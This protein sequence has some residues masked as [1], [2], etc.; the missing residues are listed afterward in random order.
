MEI[1]SIDPLICMLTLSAT[2]PFFIGVSA[3]VVFCLILMCALLLCS[4]MAS[5]SETA[6][7]S[8]Q[9]NDIN[10]LESSQN[11]NEQLVLEIRQKPKTLLVTILIFNNL[12][13]ISITIFSTYIM[14]MMFNLAVNPIAAFILNVI[15]V[16]SLIL[17]VGEM[18]PKV[19]ASKKAKSI[20]VLMAPILKVLILIFKPLS[21]VFVSSTSFI[22]KK[23][24]KKTGSISLS[25]LSTA[26]DIATE[27]GSSPEEKNMLKGIAT[28]GEKEVSDIMRPRVNM[29]SVSLETDFEELMKQVVD[30]GFSRIPVYDKDLDDVKGILYV[31]DLLPYIDEK[32]FAWQKLLR[33]A[34]FVPEN[35]KIND[36]FQ[37]FRAKKI[38]IAIVVDE[39]G[40]TSG[41][42]T[43][44]DIVEEIV[45]DISD[46]FDK[47]PEND[48]YKKI[49]NETYIFKAQISIVDFCKV[50]GIND[51]Y[52][53]EIEGESDTLAGII[54]EM[55]GR[56][57]E[58]GFKCSYKEFTFEIVESD[59]KHIIKIKVIRKDENI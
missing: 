48:N 18:I 16:T 43:L 55:E 26:V 11:H 42:V 46:E 7:F 52:F 54:L 40:G 37:D 8:L 51:D 30:K 32:D 5:S 50:F 10:E 44:E 53:E 35:K 13:N 22:D 23:L 28:F 57:P 27:E 2:E 12:V 9:P 41:L 45:G 59:N 34:F 29:F 56:I 36:L 49:D 20:A 25:D 1:A 17:L 31:K 21:N 33:P 38:H 24:V 14:S 58:T 3:K 15:V 4:A 39:Y 19:Y 47:E 6:Y